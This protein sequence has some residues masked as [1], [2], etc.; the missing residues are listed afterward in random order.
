MIFGRKGQALKHQS[1]ER[2]EQ[3]SRGLEAK[4]NGVPLPI[5]SPQEGDL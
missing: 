3:E 5:E 2:M 4:K 1:I